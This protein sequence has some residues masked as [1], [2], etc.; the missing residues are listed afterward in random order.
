MAAVACCAGQSS[1]GQGATCTSRRHRPVHAGVCCS[2][3][4][5]PSGLRPAGCMF[6]SPRPQPM[7]TVPLLSIEPSEVSSSNK[8]SEL[9]C[10]RPGRRGHTASASTAQQLGAGQHA[11]RLAARA[12]EGF[13]GSCNVR[14]VVVPKPQQAAFP[15]FMQ[16]VYANAGMHAYAPHYRSL[17]CC[18][19][20]MMHRAARQ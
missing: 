3:T 14:Q 7:V 9:T 8:S 19:P 13:A 6:R 20:S 15:R 5:A 11:R 12:V 2:A 16:A 10:S 17:P 18:L 1:A 4:A